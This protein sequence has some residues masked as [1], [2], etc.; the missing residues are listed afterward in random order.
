MLAEAQERKQQDEKDAVV[1]GGGG[2]AKA[3]ADENKDDEMNM[4]ESGAAGS[5][6]SAAELMN[7]DAAAI[8]SRATATAAAI[9][10]T[11]LTK[12]GHYLDQFCS[13]WIVGI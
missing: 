3:N 8:I 13:L 7:I 2:S 10:D 6:T 1:E 9:I 11:E 12:N 4:D 5:V